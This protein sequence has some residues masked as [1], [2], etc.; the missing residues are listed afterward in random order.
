MSSSKLDKK[1]P[2]VCLCFRDLQKSMGLFYFVS[3]GISELYPL[4]DCIPDLIL[5]FASDKSG[6]QSNAG[7]NYHVCKVIA[8]IALLIPS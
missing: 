7:Y 6:I 1:I 5:G 8:K 4:F 3:H 2:C